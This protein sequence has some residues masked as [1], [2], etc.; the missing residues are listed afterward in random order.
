M[1]RIFIFLVLI[2]S[3]LVGTNAL[4]INNTIPN[5]INTYNINYNN[6]ISCQDTQV[7][8]FNT[9]NTNTTFYLNNFSYD[10]INNSLN[11]SN[12]SNNF[13]KDDSTFS[14]YQ[15]TT[16]GSNQYFEGPE[17]FFGDLFLSSVYIKATASSSAAGVDR[18]IY[19]QGFDGST[20]SNIANSG[21][22]DNIG[23]GTWEKNLSLNNSYEGLR[24]RFFHG[25]TGGSTF[26]YI[27]YEIEP[28]NYDL[29]LIYNYSTSG[30][31]SYAIFASNSTN[32]INETGQVLVNPLATF[33]FQLANGSSITGLTLGGK[34]DNNTGFVQYKYYGEGLIIGNN[35][36]EFIKEG[37]NTQTINFELNDSSP[38]Y[39]ETFNATEISLNIF[40]R[41]KNNN[42]IISGPTFNLEFIGPVGLLTNTSTGQKTITQTFLE[43]DYEL[44]LSNSD[45]LSESIFFYFQNVEDIDL[46]IYTFNSTN[47][48]AGVVEIK[49]VD[50]FGAGV[51]GAL[52]QALQWDVD[53]SSF[54]RVSEGKTVEDGV[55]ILNIILDTKTYIFQAS[56]DN[57]FKNSSQQKIPTVLNGKQIIL[58]L[59]QGKTEAT[60]LLENIEYTSQESFLNYTSNISLSFSTIDGTD[61]TGCIRYSRLQPSGIKTVLSEDCSTGSVV[62]NFMVSK[63]LNSS[64][65]IIAEIGFKINGLFYIVNDYRYNPSFSISNILEET[66]I[67]LYVLPLLYLIAVFVGMTNPVIGAAIL[68]LDNLLAVII[69]PQYVNGEIFAFM[70]LIAGLIMYAGGKRK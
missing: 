50:E 14:Q 38:A 41:D 63:A 61:A 22:I 68:I 7:C 65:Y 58:S 31:K 20:W 56:K 32:T 35:S 64:Y 57:L 55:A 46:T 34:S 44:T 11:F 4:S 39:N 60:G 28:L 48:N 17:M 62:S 51:S 13:D 42:Q 36:L 26:T 66:N 29:D 1:N 47:E 5:E 27:A 70:Y 59:D 43:G 6:F 23:T 21:L 25:S 10:S 67:A 33:N 69:I 54:V 18:R 16:G 53:S 2:L 49:V 19:L 8:I 30:N 37:F 52:V 45:Y 9:N 40:I 3:M 12:P 24:F 15:I